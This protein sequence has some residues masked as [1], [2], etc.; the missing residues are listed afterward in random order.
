MWISL[1]FPTIS[2]SCAA[3]CFLH[4]VRAGLLVILGMTMIT[5]LP[6]NFTACPDLILA[7]FSGRINYEV[8]EQIK[9]RARFSEFTAWGISGKIWWDERNKNWFAEVWKKNI[10]LSTISAPLLE[11]LAFRIQKEFGWK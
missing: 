11:D 1:S 2:T 3:L 5:T 7:G 8:A 9:N 4:T 6:K 10:L